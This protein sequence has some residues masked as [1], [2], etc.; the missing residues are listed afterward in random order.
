MEPVILPRAKRAFDVGVS[1]LLLTLLSPAIIL[2]LIAIALESI[3]FPSSRGPLL[4]SEIRISQGKPFTFYK[5]R[6][7]KVAAISKARNGNGVVHTKVLERETGAMTRVGRFLKMIYFD[8][9]GQFINVLRGDMSL[10]GPRPT[11]VENYERGLA[12]GLQAKRI[13]RAGVTGYF[14]SHKGMRLAQ[15]QEEID[16]A[17]ARM[18]KK[19]P[20]WKI[21]AYDSYILLVTVLTVLRSEGL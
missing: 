6:T 19:G 21:L 3:F 13:L 18:C 16:L 4:Y 10:V 5:I 7:F 14:Q 17:Y 15:N 20:V 11:N 2:I 8:E 12:K 9:L 1:L